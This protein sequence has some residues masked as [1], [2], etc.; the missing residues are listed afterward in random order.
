M[1]IKHSK[2]GKSSM[3]FKRNWQLYIMVSI[4]LLFIVTFAYAPMGGIVLA[5]KDYSIRKGIFG[6]PWVGFEHFETF[7]SSPLFDTLL[8]NTIILSLYSFIAGFIFPI[9]LALFIHEVISAKFKKAVQMITFFPYLISVVIVTGMLL[10]FLALN[11][12][13]INNLINIFGGESINFMGNPKYFRHIYVW[14]GVWQNAGYGAVI[15]IAALSGI[16]PQLEESAIL[17]G[18]SRIKRI[19]HI[20]LPSIAPTITIMLLLGIGGIMNIGFEKAYLMQNN[21]NL[22]VSEL[23]STYIYKRGLLNFQFSYSTAIG[24]FNSIV[25]LILLISA[26]LISKRIGKTSLW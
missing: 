19:W 5:F 2:A 1:H 25:N 14:S 7:L 10:Q 4:P 8:S 11:G 3:D 22:D 13:L 18:V 12:G 17:D 16:D 26:N 24:L 9:L 23:I 15:Y 6:S 21:L 20:D